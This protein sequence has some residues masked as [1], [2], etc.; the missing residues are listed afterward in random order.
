M[1]TIGMRGIHDGSMEG[2]RTMEEKAEGLQQVIDDQQKMIAELLGK[3]E[4]QMQVFV[5]YKEVLEL[6]ERGVRVP[7]ASP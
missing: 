4:E 7:P 6:Y 2:Y 5:P 1:F 3:P